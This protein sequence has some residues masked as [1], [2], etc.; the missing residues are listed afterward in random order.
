MKDGSNSS[1]KAYF[2]MTFLFA[3]LY[4]YSIFDDIMYNILNKKSTKYVD[5]NMH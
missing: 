2:Y 3:F 1:I 5:K 4:E